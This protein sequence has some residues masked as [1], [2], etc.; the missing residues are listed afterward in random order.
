M[1]IN[2]FGFT[3]SVSGRINYDGITYTAITGFNDVRISRDGSGTVFDRAIMQFDTGAFFSSLTVQSIDIVELLVRNNTSQP[4]NMPNL[5]SIWIGNWVGAVL[6]G[7]AADYNGG[8]IMLNLSGQLVDNT[9]YDLADQGNDP[10]IY[11]SLTG[12][13]DIAIHDD[14]V[15]ALDTGQN[16]NTAKVKCQLRITYTLIGGAK[17]V[18]MINSL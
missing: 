13:T 4:A 1:A 7:S 11:V 16:Y 2:S 14:S 18:I 3:D 8:N 12:T 5:V 17:Q 15:G 6:N 9:L 10:T